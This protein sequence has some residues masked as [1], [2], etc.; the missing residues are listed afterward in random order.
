M[1][2]KTKVSCDSA[3]LDIQSEIQ[4]PSSECPL[5]VLK[6]FGQQGKEMPETLKKCK[7]QS[8]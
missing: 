3:N 1:N 8:I 4:T 2:L 6:Y 5:L 7:F